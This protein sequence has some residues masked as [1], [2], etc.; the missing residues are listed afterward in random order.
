LIKEWLA[1]QE[2]KRCEDA[3][4]TSSFFLSAS[5][6]NFSLSSVRFIFLAGAAFGVSVTAYQHITNTATSIPNQP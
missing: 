6:N 2:Q 3:N 5:A 4:N 1:E